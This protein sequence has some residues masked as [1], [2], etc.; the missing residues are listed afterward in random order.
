MAISEATAP[1]AETR[2]RGSG[3]EMACWAGLL[4]VTSLGYVWLI[5]QLFSTVGCEG[6][7]D[8]ELIFGTW[9]AAPWL[10]FGTAGVAVATG[11]VLA[12]LGRRSL[13]VAV[14]GL[15]LVTAIVGGSSLLFEAGFQPMR[16]RNARAAQGILPAPPPP[17]DP[18]GRWSI[19]G[20]ETPPN[21]DLA[22]DG[23]LAADNGCS[24]YAGTW[25]QEP[26][27]TIQLDFTSVTDLVCDGVGIWL[28]HAASAMVIDD[29]LVVSGEEGT[30][31]G[32][33]ETDR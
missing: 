10:L 12:A 22:A 30:P 26:D 6:I 33:L 16:E 3:W 8:S 2:E 9:A 13:W 17:P 14:T 1:D 24:S 27:G 4:L 31:I 28:T 20:S 29:R 32:V 18:T 15:V 25:Q 11:L 5:L 7:C 19:D 21:L 23:T